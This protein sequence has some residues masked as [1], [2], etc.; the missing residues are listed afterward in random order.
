MKYLTPQEYAAEMDVA[1]GTVLRWCRSGLV[2]SYRVGGRWRI[3]ISP[4]DMPEPSSES[5]NEILSQIR[6]G[7]KQAGW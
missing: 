1:H 3:P 5:E 7:M 6:K 4:E 2:E